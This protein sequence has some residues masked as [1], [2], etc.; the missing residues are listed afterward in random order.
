MTSHFNF[1]GRK[2]KQI[3]EDSY[4]FPKGFSFL[5][6]IGIQGTSQNRHDLLSLVL[7]GKKEQYNFH[8]T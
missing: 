3:T 5:V 1:T 6:A 4:M 2:L 7:G 8:R